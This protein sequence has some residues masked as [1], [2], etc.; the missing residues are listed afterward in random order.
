MRV[1]RR[2]LY[3]LPGLLAISMLYLA[4]F[5]A[6]YLQSFPPMDTCRYVVIDVYGVLGRT[7]IADDRCYKAG[8]TVNELRALG[9]LNAERIIIVT[10]FFSSGGGVN[11]LGTSNPVTPWVFL[12]HP[13][14]LPFL[15]KG[16][17]PNGREYVSVR[18]TAL[19]FSTGYKGKEIVIIS[20]PLHGVESFLTA[21]PGAKLVAVTAKDVT[22]DSAEHYVR[23]AVEANDI[24]ALCAEGVF[25]CR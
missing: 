10:H 8:M 1:P 3:V 15:V 13:L 16:V 7:P 19:R 21:F 25:I 18:A 22:V 6:P 14:L 11:G 23:L 12:Q 4:D 9:K 2:V 5:A 24:R 20:C 17:L